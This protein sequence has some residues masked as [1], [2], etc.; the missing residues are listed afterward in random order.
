MAKFVEGLAARGYAVSLVLPDRARG[1]VPP[2]QYGSLGCEEVRVRGIPLPFYR[3]LRF[4]LPSRGFLRKVFSAQ[5]PQVVYVATQ[6]PL[7][8][9]ALRAAKALGIPVVTGFHTNF[10][11]Y[12]N[13]YG[14]PLLGKI[15][16]HYLR[17]FHNSSD[18]TVVPSGDLI[19]VLDEIGIRNSQILPRGVDSDRFSPTHRC[20][21]L[22]QSWGAD[23]RTTVVTYVGRLAVEKNIEL[24]IESYLGIKREVKDAKLVIVGD[25]PLRSRLESLHQEPDIIFAGFKTGHELARYYAS[26][27][28]FLFPSETETFGNVVLEAL[29]SGLGVVA[30]KYAAAKMHI[31]HLQS[32][33]LAPLK[34]PQTFV[35]LCCNIAADPLRLRSL[36]VKARQVAADVSWSSVIL[37]LE[38]IFESS[39]RRHRESFPRASMVPTGHSGHAISPVTRSVS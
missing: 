23:E 5:R 30:Y 1:D 13:H 10:H 8:I 20:D 25:G 9:S 33:I 32:G 6:G 16:K 28:L 3:D 31:E 7:G 38:S 37:Q 4:G 11:Q 12:L 21:E 29:A 2:E 18:Q 17:W 27:D 14:F 34:E 24:A 36:R 35:K 19:N 39:L 15:A 26:S 22:R